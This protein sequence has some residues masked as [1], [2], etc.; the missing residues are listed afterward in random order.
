MDTRT[1]LPNEPSIAV[2]DEQIASGESTPPPTVQGQ[3]TETSLVELSALL[4]VILTGMALVFIGAI[5]I[6][7]W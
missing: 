5:I 4:I 6:V 2:F 3:L 7:C 1:S